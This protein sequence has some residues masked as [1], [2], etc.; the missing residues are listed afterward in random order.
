MPEKTL[1][2][3]P[4]EAKKLWEKVYEENKDKGEERAAKIAWGA[5]K[6]LY[7]KEDE[8]WVKTEMEATYRKEL[9]RLGKYTHPQRPGKTV[10][11]T[12][13]RLRTWVDNFNAYKSEGGKVWL[14]YRHSRNPKD[15]TGW[16]EEM[17][18]EGDRLYGVVKVAD[19]E[20]AKRI[21]SATIKDV[22]IGVES[23]VVM[24]SGKVYDELIKHVALTLDP[25]IREQEGFI[26]ME[27]E[28]FNGF[29]LSAD[30]REE[31]P[32]AEDMSV[33]S[34]LGNLLGKANINVFQGGDVMDEKTKVEFEARLDSLN[35]K[36]EAMAEEN[37]E[38]KTEL[39]ASKARLTEYEAA[40]AKRKE[41]E[42]AAFKAEAETAADKLIKA[43]KLLPAKR[44][45]FVKLYLA[46][47]D[48][49]LEAARG[50]GLD[51]E[52]PEGEPIEEGKP[53]KEGDLTAGQKAAYDW[54]T[55]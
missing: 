20:A 43:E 26:P 3:L 45:K 12:P 46:D 25:H 19:E 48:L 47:K 11:V 35:A 40:E 53:G 41:E 42:E 16:V 37:A 6:R 52:A 31:E 10:D 8:E 27:G 23:N 54:L 49:A 5:V 34:K 32:K 33:F 28:E 44:D 14:P 17:F 7:H 1:E 38:L 2:G 55:S 21:Q 51:F 30:Y 4:E 13:D 39:E 29:Y 50:M 18:I 36:F 15:N 9:I 22:S 24:D